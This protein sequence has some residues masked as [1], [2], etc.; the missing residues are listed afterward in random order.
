MQFIKTPLFNMHRRRKQGVHSKFEKTQSLY[1]TYYVSHWD[2]LK[3]PFSLAS[4]HQ[5]SAII[6]ATSRENLYLH[7][8]RQRRRLAARLRRS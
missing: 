6:S 5:L 1:D 7:M 4:R 2:L 3:W 8:P